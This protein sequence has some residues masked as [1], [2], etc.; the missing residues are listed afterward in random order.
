[1]LTVQTAVT[2]SIAQFQY[3]PYLPFIYSWYN[4][5]TK[6]LNTHIIEVNFSQSRKAMYVQVLG[7][8]ERLSQSWSTTSQ[9]EST[10]VL[11]RQKDGSRISVPCPMSVL[12][13][14]TYMGSIDRG[15]QVRGYY[16]CRTKRRKFYKYIF[17]F[18]LDVA[19]TNA[20][21]LQK[22]YCEDAPFSSIK[23]FELKL[24]SELIGDHCSRKRAGRS[25]GVVCSFALRQFLPPFLRA[26]PPKKA[27]A[28]ASTLHQVLQ[29]DKME[30]IHLVVLYLVSCVAVSYRRAEHRLL[31]DVARSTRPWT[32][33]KLIFIVTVVFSYVTIYLR[34]L[35]DTAS[36]CSKHILYN[37]V[38][39]RTYKEPTN[40]TNTRAII[41]T[42][43]PIVYSYFVKLDMQYLPELNC[44]NLVSR[45]DVYDRLG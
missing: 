44:S 6:Q 26:I 45:A 39:Q 28:Q 14:N 24:A 29:P 25:G 4:L 43:T 10:N 7:W 5:H 40:W 8:I 9:P 22:G 19:V 16:S 2:H 27:K 31:H 18:L 21:I 34:Q 15:D 33:T 12:D 1:M 32:V 30:C 23:E 11:R 35:S 41:T 38:G 17:H 42:Y 13:Y 20:F 37:L 3:S 36:V